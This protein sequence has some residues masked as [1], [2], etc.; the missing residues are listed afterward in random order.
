[1]PNVSLGTVSAILENTTG[2]G[3]LIEMTAAAPFSKVTQISNQLCLTPDVR[4]DND[5]E[6]PVHHEINNHCVQSR[7]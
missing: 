2:Q 6:E 4:Q 3:E 7:L 5:I 1:M